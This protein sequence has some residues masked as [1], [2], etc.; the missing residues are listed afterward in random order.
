MSEETVNA[1]LEHWKR[2]LLDLTRR[3]RLLN[4]KPSKTTTIVIVGELPSQVFKMLA[5]DERAMRFGAADVPEDESE[6]S[7]DDDTLQDFELHAPRTS[8]AALNQRHLDLVLETRLSAAQLDHKLRRIADQASSVL[9]EQGVHTLFLALGMLHWFDADDSDDERRA[10]ILLLPVNLTRKA[11]GGSY[12]ISAGEE[13]PILNPALIEYLRTSFAITLP[14]LPEITDDYDPST[15]YDDVARCVATKARWKVTNEIVLGLFSFQKFVMFKDL[16]RHREAYANHRLIRQLATRKGGNGFGLPDGVA[17]LVLDDAFPAESTFQV[18]DADSSQLRA[19]AAVS[20]G[21]DLVLQGPPGTGKSQTITNL[22]AHALGTGK[23]VLFVSEKMAALEVVFGRLKAVGLGDFCLELHGPKSNKRAVMAEIGRALDNSLTVPNDRTVDGERLR[24]VRSKITEYAKALHEPQLP[25]GLTPFQAY[26]RLAA[27]GEAPSIRL[28]ES[29]E[30][31][32]AAMLEEAKRHLDDLAAAAAAIGDPSEHPWRDT[33]CTY[34][35]SDLRTDLEDQLDRLLSACSVFAALA[36]QVEAELGLPQL[37][38]LADADRAAVVASVI[39]RSPGATLDVLQSDVWNSPPPKA[40]ELIDLGQR[41]TD[42][43]AGALERFKADV[44]DRDHSD[45]ASVIDRLH[46]KFYRMVSGDFRRVRKAWLACR[47]SGYSA[48][49]AEQ[50]AHMRDVDRV[51]R[52]LRTLADADSSARQLFGALWRGETSDWDSLRRYVEWVVDFRSICIKHGLK[53]ETAQRASLA[54]PDVSTCRKLVD[55]AKT[56][57]ELLVSVGRSVGWPDGHLRDARVSDVHA[58]TAAMR[59]H[60]GRHTEWVAFHNAR[61]AVEGGAAAEALK[62]AGGAPYSLLKPAFERAFLQRWLDT[63]VQQRPALLEF[64]VVT[65][66]QRVGEFQRLDR[67][68][69]GDNR[70][71]L[72]GAQRTSVQQRLRELRD[73]DGMRFLRGQLTRQRGLAPLRKTLQHAH[74]PIK[75]IKPCFMMS[76]LTVAQFLN[77]ND[78]MFD[79]VV[80]D[81]ASQLTAEDAVGAVVRGRQLVVVGDPKQLPPTNFFAVQSGQVEPERGQDGEALVE[82]MESILEQFMATGLPTARLRWHYRSRHESLITFSNVNFYDS[83]LYT[84]PS[85]D[86]DTRERGLQFLYVEDGLY[87]GAGLNRAEARRVADAVVQFAREQLAEPDELQ[88]LTLGVGTFNLRQQIAIQDELESRRRQDPSLEPFFAPR[89][90]GAFFVKNLENIQGDDRDVIF[91]SVTYARALDGRLRHNFG[92]INGDNG[93]RRLNVLTTRSRLRM[94]VFSSIRGDDI[95]LSKTSAAGARYLKDFLSFAERGDLVGDI[96]AAGAKTESP[97]EYGV[98]QELTRE[99]F[100]VV[101]QVGVAGYRIDL[102]IKDEE[103][104]G[105][106]VCGIECDGVA[107]HSA[108]SAR[109]RDRLRQEVLEGL[110]WTLHRVWSTDWFKDREGTGRRLIEKIRRS[111]RLAR[112]KKNGPPPPSAASSARDPGPDALEPAGTAKAWTTDLEKRDAEPYRFCTLGTRNRGAGVLATSPELLVTAVAEVVRIESPVHEDDVMFRVAL[113]FGD[114]KV[115]SRIGRDLDSALALAQHRGLIVRRKG[116][117]WLPNGEARPR[118]RAGTGIPADRIAPEE[119]E[120]AALTV[121][122][123]GTRPRKDLIA[124]TRMLL[125]FNR[126]GSKLEERIEEAVDYLVR[127]GRIGEGSGG[128]AIIDAVDARASS[129]TVSFPR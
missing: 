3:N 84:F 17:S 9:E 83:E 39:E 125:G 33:T 62:E 86:T 45:D 46:G 98:L 2:K 15:L 48:T 21:N 14:E 20:K 114:Q 32:S 6:T 112:E 106:F 97:F 43:K 128:M 102:A 7:A 19:V 107:Y 24:A 68:V 91:L 37:A 103:V 40:V 49:L 88:R 75:A 66:E 124:G 34:Y 87:E 70:T 13:D 105:R 30:R 78:H 38:T 29:V 58:R 61:T 122:R 8:D 67:A 42:G 59:D 111:Q 73:D 95:D 96:I 51:R 26:G 47:S 77:P 117:A 99:G 108:E 4:F 41:A 118:S 54:T 65:H 16:E 60:F 81:E 25:L 52:E 127:D 110:G 50:V 10:P 129:S 85:A 1:N 12:T 93:W 36:P 63:V 94:R 80:F 69:L 116:F 74:K 53:E 35:S 55:C 71:V 123:T 115:G 22:I 104:P 90:E 72:I 31:V 79:L 113:A 101:P 18:V 100:D 57:S 119:Y 109:D 82:D 56:I 27:L 5:V 92:P 28:R 121:L 11:A 44:L 89:D 120:A 126:T 23:S 76:P 64:Q